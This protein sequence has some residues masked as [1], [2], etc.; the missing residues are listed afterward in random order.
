M[1]QD[2]SITGIANK[3]GVENPALQGRACSNKATSKATS[4]LHY[5]LRTITHHSQK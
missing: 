4:D 1:N 2:G 5:D 3:A